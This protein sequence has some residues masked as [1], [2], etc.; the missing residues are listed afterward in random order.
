MK[1]LLQNNYSRIGK[2][3]SDLNRYQDSI[4]NF[5]ESN[6]YHIKNDKFSDERY[7]L[8]NGFLAYSYS[9]INDWVKTKQL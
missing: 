7:S 4:K 1:I 8:N 9:Q 6:K 2:L 5:T 3:Q